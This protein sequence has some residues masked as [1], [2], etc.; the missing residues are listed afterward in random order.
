MH[1][2]WQGGTEDAI[3]RMD[4]SNRWKDQWRG[5]SRYSLVERSGSEVGWSMVD[6]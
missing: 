1:T 4:C 5:M 3:R 6:L 2:G